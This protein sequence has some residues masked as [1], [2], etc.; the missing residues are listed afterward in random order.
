M[1]LDQAARSIF[2]E[3]F[4]AGVLNID[5]LFLQAEGDAQLSV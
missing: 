3:E 4:V 1:R 5:A 2:L